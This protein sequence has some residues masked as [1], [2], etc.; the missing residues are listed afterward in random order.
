M[1]TP[2]V[3]RSSQLPLAASALALAAALL[4]AAAISVPAQ[5]PAGGSSPP[6]PG[7]WHVM[8]YDWNRLATLAAARSAPPAIAADDPEAAAKQAAHQQAQQQVAIQNEYRVNQR[9]LGYSRDLRQAM[10]RGGPTEPVLR[11]FSPSAVRWFVDHE[12]RL[13]AMNTARPGEPADERERRVKALDALCRYGPPLVDFRARV[14]SAARRAIAVVTE[15]GQTYYVLLHQLENDDWVFSYF[16]HAD[17]A[18]WTPLLIQEKM[19]RGEPLFDFERE[20]ATRGK[21][22]HQE[23]F[24]N[25]CVATG[26]PVPP[27][28]TAY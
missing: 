1:T 12:E 7:E 5:R 18:I 8:G 17:I 16:F 23:D 15:G 2:H 4:L 26:A 25:L 19:A 9:L 10:L 24:L 22:R 20:F 3:H 14:H 28:F 27:Q 21:Q 11:H 6:P 13:A